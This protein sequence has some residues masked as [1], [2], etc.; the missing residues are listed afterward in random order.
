MARITEITSMCK[1]GK[2]AEAYAAACQDMNTMPDNI[3]S[4]RAMFWALY[5]S[6]KADIAGNNLQNALSR[7]DEILNLSLIRTESDQI[8]LNNVSSMNIL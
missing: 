6:A 5:Y 7:L 8:I 1:E 2:L 4:Q 3:W